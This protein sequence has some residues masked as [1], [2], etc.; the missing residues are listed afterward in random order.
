MDTNVAEALLVS[1]G[2]PPDKA[3][4]LFARLSDR[5]REVANL[6]ADGLSVKQV[7]LQLAISPKTVEVHK[8]HIRDRLQ[9]DTDRSTVEVLKV[10]L[11]ARTVEAL[12]EVD[13][14]A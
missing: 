7:A 14:T 4:E 9:T 12:R 11:L 13:A 1:F 3:V 10:I 2:I 6:L 5:E 8:R